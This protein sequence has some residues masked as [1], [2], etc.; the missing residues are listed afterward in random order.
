M[1]NKALLLI[2][3]LFAT[4]SLFAQDNKFKLGIR[5]APMFAFNKVADNNDNDS[6]NFETNGV[7]LRFSAGFFGDFH[8]GSNYAFHTGLWYTVNR[9]AMKY[10]STDPLIKNGNAVYNLQQVQIPVA[11]KLFTNEISTD[12]KLYFTLGGTFSLKINEKRLEWASDNDYFTRPGTGNAFVFGDVG[13]LLG[14]GVE[15]QLAESTIFYGGITYN[16]G[17]I[18]AVRKEGV[19]IDKKNNK[20][21]SE[22]YTLNNQLMGLELGIKF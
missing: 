3:L 10:T 19:F 7:G 8:F 13:L 12:M 16:R 14:M 9:G 17:L 15:Y 11:L 18:D 1:K 20:D 22:Y 21:A 4:S 5:F 6:I 2:L